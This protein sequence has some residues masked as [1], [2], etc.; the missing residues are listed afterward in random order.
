MS[1]GKKQVQENKWL[2]EDE[3]ENR[4]E[5]RFNDKSGSSSNLMTILGGGAAVAVAFGATFFFL[6]MAPSGTTAQPPGPVF[7]SSD[8]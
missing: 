3:L 8:A 4:L 2:D 1:F 7:V 5:Q 6:D